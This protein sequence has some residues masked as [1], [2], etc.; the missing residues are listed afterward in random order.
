MFPRKFPF[1]TT[2]NMTRPLFLL[3]AVGVIGVSAIL[4]RQTSLVRDSINFL[5]ERSGE[6]PLGTSGI[7]VPSRRELC[8]RIGDQ[9]TSG[10]AYQRAGSNPASCASLIARV[11]AYAPDEPGAD[12]Y[13]RRR[14]CSSDVRLRLRAGHCSVDPRLIPYGSLVKVEGW[15]TFR[16]VDTGDAVVNQRASRRK[17]PIIDVFFERWQEALEAVEQKP[18]IVKVEVL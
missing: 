6:C 16:A 2:P 15:G 14:K 13:T 7:A 17:F 4:I 8:T 3:V 12:W 18:K 5:Q 9:R 10:L 1:N 11:T